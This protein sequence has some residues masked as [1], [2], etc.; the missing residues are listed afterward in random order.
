MANTTLSPDQ[1][2]QTI[3]G[4]SPLTDT[5]RILVL[6]C[7][8]FLST[9]TSR[10][11]RWVLVRLLSFAGIPQKFI[12]MVTGYGERQIRT[13]KGK[14]DEELDHPRVFRGAPRKVDGD[15][16]QQLA[17]YLVAHP[18]ATPSELALEKGYPIATD[19]I[20]ATCESLVKDRMEHSGMRW[21]IAGAQ[22][23]LAQQAVVKNGDWNDFWRY[24]IAVERQRLYPTVYQRAALCQKAA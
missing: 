8:D 9:S 2:C 12:G 20:E 16:L 13:L 23:V 11:V 22:A 21:S 24:F 3:E 19:T 18:Q 4:Y 5:Q 10:C 7:Y 17:I 15:A 14:P 6:I 1:I